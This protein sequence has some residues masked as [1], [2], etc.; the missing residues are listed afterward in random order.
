MAS[1][2]GGILTNLVLFAPL[3]A[4]PVLAIT[5][6]PSAPP[7]SA[8]SSVEATLT[9]SAVADLESSSGS[10]ARAP[11]GGLFEAMTDAGEVLALTGSTEPHGTDGA[12]HQGHDHGDGD[13][14]SLLGRP[15]SRL[16]A[17]G[18]EASGSAWQGMEHSHED[19]AAANHEQ[20]TPRGHSGEFAGSSDFGAGQ[21]FAESSQPA[22]DTV[23]TGFAPG[24]D[25]TGFADQPPSRVNWS[26]DG[27]FDPRRELLET[28]GTEPGTPQRPVS[29]A[30]ANA[31]AFQDDPSAD[32][33]H[34]AAENSPGDFDT[35][36]AA[37]RRTSS[38]ASDQLP[39]DNL[40]ADSGRFADSSRGAAVDS[41]RQNGQGGEF[42]ARTSQDETL[43]FT[44]PGSRS[45][46]PAS[47]TDAVRQLN[48]LGIHRFQLQPGNNAESFHFSCLHTPR[49]NP[50]VTHRFEA[51]AGEPLAAVQ[52]VLEQIEQWQ[53]RQQ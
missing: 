34:A 3:V 22:G 41:S 4:V 36:A 53:R 27:Q 12:H 35:G 29:R 39:A 8:S 16:P 47:W 32:A 49:N 43:P 44:P 24:S 20:G 30:A 6:I 14:H 21:P 23:P 17:N 31:S 26:D 38:S 2:S 52:L 5:G 13:N 15:V 48:N 45:A 28:S 1:Q 25:E 51:E 46:A 37:G 9:S 33:F 42:S 40:F 18:Q 10:S 11:G 50:R 19:H 7:V